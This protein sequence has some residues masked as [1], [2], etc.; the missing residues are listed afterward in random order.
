VDNDPGRILAVDPGE[1]RLGLAVSDPTRTIASPL[2]VISHSSRIKDAREIMRIAQEQGATLIIIGHPLNWDGS[3][4][5]QAA[6][7]LKLAESLRELGSVPVELIDEYGSTQEAQQVRRE[8]AVTR[9]KRAGHLDDLAA[10]IILQHYLEN[11]E[12]AE[13]L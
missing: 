8:M 9:E 12:S 3:E 13:D 1:K 7:S 10:A 6:G 2:E 4:S 5:P 11:L